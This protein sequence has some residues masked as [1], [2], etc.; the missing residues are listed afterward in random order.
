M[1]RTMSMIRRLAS[2]NNF[3]VY[4]KLSLKL[5]PRFIMDHLQVAETGYGI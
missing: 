2:L 3:L 5:S 1:L 4:S